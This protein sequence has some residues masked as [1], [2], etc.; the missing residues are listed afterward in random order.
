MKKVS[1]STWILI[2]MV[3]GVVAG[4]FLEEKGAIFAPLGDIFILLIKMVIIPLIF[5]SI[6]SGS[7]ALGKTKSAGKVGII[8]IVYYMGTSAV[9]VILG[10][11][12]GIIFKP[13]LGVEI[14]ESLMT[15]A[16]KYA[17]NAEIAGFWETVMGIIP[18]NPFA[19]LVSGNIL[20]ILFFALFF[21][22]AVSVMPEKKQK[23]LMTLLDIINEGLIWI[24]RQVLRIAPIGVFGLMVNAIA[25][26][27][28][29]IM[30]LVLALF[31]VFSGTLALIHFGMIPALAMIFGGINPFRFLGGMKETQILAFASAS[32]MATLPI[33]K[34]DCE[35]LGVKPEVTSFVLPLGATI[36][37]NGNAMLYALTAVFFSQLFGVELGM[38]Q[39]VAIVL[40]SVLGAI[41]T[42]GVPGPALLVVAVLVAAGIPL[43]GLPLIFGVD[44]LFDMMRTSTNV[45]GDASCAV[46]INRILGKETVPAGSA[47]AVRAEA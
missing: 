41:G 6:V 47:A 38:P 33:N 30:V 5:F 43:A 18:E 7:A 26:F 20:Q 3:A 25:Q 10:L 22:I 44:R 2:A 27:G 11:L 36:N 31:A 21:G 17:E 8:T 19:S 23:P 40:T 15:D 4:F 24:I 1:S 37:M 35:A 39:Y 45:L 32:S 14:P 46:I 42:A 34:R 16:S 29:D 9:S 12:A 13:G 28:L